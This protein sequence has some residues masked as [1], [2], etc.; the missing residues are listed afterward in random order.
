MVSAGTITCRSPPVDPARAEEQVDQG[1]G[2]ALVHASGHPRAS[3]AGA[4]LLGGGGEG[5]LDLPGLH[6]RQQRPQL[7]H[8]VVA[9]GDDHPPVAPAPVADAPRPRRGQRRS[10]SAAAT[11][12]AAGRSGTDQAAV[13]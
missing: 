13:A 9:G 11:P 3:I 6:P 10:P 8:P 2:A 4:H 12:A 1:V 5:L 7:G